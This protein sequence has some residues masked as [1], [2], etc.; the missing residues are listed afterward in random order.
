MK[1]I[2]LR[3]QRKEIEQPEEMKDEGNKDQ[4][5][6]ELGIKLKMGLLESSIVKGVLP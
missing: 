5:K 1:L 2:L 6:F 4:Y 3:N